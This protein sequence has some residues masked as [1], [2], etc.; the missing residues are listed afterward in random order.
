MWLGELKSVKQFLFVLAVVSSSA[1]AYAQNPP[2]AQPVV[3]K[4]PEQRLDEVDGALDA[5]SSTLERPDVTGDELVALRD[6]LPPREAVCDSIIG[7]VQ[8]QL[9]E[10]NARVEQLGDSAEGEST[11]V[12]S[13]RSEAVKHKQELDDALKRAKLLDLKC[14]ELTTDIATK[15]REI[16]ASQLYERFPT[17]FGPTFWRQLAARAPTDWAHFTERLGDGV[18]TLDAGLSGGTLLRVI[19]ALLVFAALIFP[20]V[21]LAETLGRKLASRFLPVS[22]LQR[23]LVAVWTLAVTALFPTLGMVFVVDALESSGTVTLFMTAVLASLVVVARI[24]ALMCGLSR[25]FLSPGDPQWRIVHWSDEQ[26][27]RVKWLPLLIGL[28]S[29]AR[30]MV[31]RCN[32]LLGTSLTGSVFTR[33]VIALISGALVCV[34]MWRVSRIRLEVV[35]EQRKTDAKPPRRG[36]VP[37]AFL[38]G[39]AWIA[40]VVAGVALMLGFNA[41]CIFWVRQIQQIAVVSLVL[42]LA[43]MLT[44]DIFDALLGE[45]FPIGRFL[46]RAVGLST[47]YMSQIAVALAGAARL[48]LIYIA[49]RIVLLRMSGEDVSSVTGKVQDSI[50]DLRIGEVTISPTAILGAIVV[51]A[52]VV[53]ATRAVQRWLDT[54]YLPHTQLD[55]GARNSIGTGV[56]YVG[57]IAAVLLAIAYLGVSFDKVALIASALSVGIGFGLQQI[58]SNFVSGLI[59]LV[60][61]PIKV[62]DLVNVSGS[63]GDVKKISV[64]ATE[65]L[66]GDGSTYVV[67]NADL[68]SK[69]IVNKTRVGVRGQVQFLMRI[70]YDVD[71]NRAREVVL[72]A[73]R[74]NEVVL[75][76]PPPAVFIDDVDD[77]GYVFN[78]VG[79]TKS[80]RE[81]YGAKSDLFFEIT[82]RLRAERMPIGSPIASVKM[83]SLP[84]PVGDEDPDEEVKAAEAAKANAADADEGDSRD[85]VSD[86]ADVKKPEPD[87]TDS[88]DDRPAMGDGKGVGGGGGGGGH[89]PA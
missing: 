6:Q 47:S 36:A 72:E 38:M 29:G 62:G 53:F 70:S 2:A 68:I 23:T 56:G 76:D 71:P 45:H 34:L 78:I 20:G 57:F 60:E 32:E 69:P 4:T 85:V 12:A 37:T 22:R 14:K 81:T 52:V 75:N 46:R 84:A 31:E 1:I 42:Q 73:M 87:G 41:L 40:L 54:T 21:R 11:D 16:F 50:S 58:I 67:P 28:A 5:I 8:P 79:N 65:I 51:F 82:K 64:R 59:L 88:A 89:T 66:L 19:I 49:V 10:V 24:A 86:I 7:A 18:R 27:A 3:E 15:R 26:V 17:I 9:D 30:L 77:R 74:D 25:A 48:I 80:P 44:D 35:A 61:R 55:S 83:A 39:A 63:T 43:T 33:T 13:E